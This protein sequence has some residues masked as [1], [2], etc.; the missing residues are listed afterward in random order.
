MPIVFNPHVGGIQ[1][2]GGKILFSSHPAALQ[3]DI[4]GT[5]PNPEPCCQSMLGTFIIDRTDPS[6]L[7]KQCVWRKYF[8]AS[9]PFPH[10]GCN[11][12]VQAVITTSKINVHIE[13]HRV[14]CPG[15]GDES[16]DEW[17]FRKT[18]ICTGVGACF[19]R[20]QLTLVPDLPGPISN[21]CE[22]EGVSM[23]VTSLP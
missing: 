20:T 19:D 2:I 11:I 16:F 18:D 12:N 15:F 3:I 8:F 4:E 10:C 13:H 22:Q 5:V 23:Y 14:D 21:W 6:G 9:Q 17:H 1:F 7:G